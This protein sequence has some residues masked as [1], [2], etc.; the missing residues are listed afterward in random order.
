[1]DYDNCGHTS[2]GVFGVLIAVISCAE[3]STSVVGEFF[4]LVLR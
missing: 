2:L 4:A 3:P 1:M